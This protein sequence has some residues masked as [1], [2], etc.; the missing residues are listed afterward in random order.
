MQSLDPGGQRAEEEDVLLGE[1]RNQKQGASGA[2]QSSDDP[3]K[4]LRQDEAA[5]W[6]R[7]DEDGQQRPFRLV[8]IK[9]K[10]DEQRQEFRTR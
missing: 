9:S 3:I 6:L 7:H 5:F 4:T 2:N 8:K 10:G 1:E